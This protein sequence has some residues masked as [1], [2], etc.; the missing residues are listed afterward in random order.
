MWSEQL[1]GGV[2]F[3][4]W[5]RRLYGKRAEDLDT[6]EWKDVGANL[7]L[8]L[9]NLAVLYAP[10]VIG[11]GGGIVT[12]NGPRFLPVAEKTMRETMRLVPPPSIVSSALGYNTAL[13][14]AIAL[15]QDCA[16]SQRE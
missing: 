3:R 7:G 10:D 8:G 1:F 4:Q 15:A 14:G 11:L 2:G 6:D 13:L 5:H 16:S 9:R 12:G